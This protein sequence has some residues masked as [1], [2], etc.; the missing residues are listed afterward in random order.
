MT[1]LIETYHPSFRLPTNKDIPIWRYLDLAKYLSMLNSQSLY[2][3][4]AT[5]LGDPFEGSST[6]LIVEARKYI[7]ANKATSPA[8]AAFKDMSDK[9][10]E[11]LW[12]ANKLMIKSYL[13]SCWH[14]KEH[15][16]SGDVEAVYKFQR[17]RLL[18]STYRRLRLCLPKCVLIGEVTYIN[19]E[20]DGF[21]VDNLSNFIMHKRLS[22][23]HERELRAIFWERDGT[24]EAQPYKTKI[25]P[26]GVA[27]DVDLSALVERVYVSPAAAPWFAN[28][29][30]A[31][32]EKCG[33]TFPVIQSALAAEPLF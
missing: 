13:I 10:I 26:N 9:S 3:S 31:M 33:F 2:F 22:F 8:L 1:E 19:Y 6:K 18:Q 11:G 12:K 15:K 23:E 7:L 20:T 28:L 5:L 16:I 29:V 24:P 14:M 21:N 27:I 30:K 25:T 32:T 17:R 4:R